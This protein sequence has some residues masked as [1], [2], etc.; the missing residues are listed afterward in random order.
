MYFK[1]L[2][3]NN[4]ASSFCIFV[5]LEIPLAQFFCKSRIRR[6]NTFIKS[7]KL[8]SHIDFLVY[9]AFFIDILCFVSPDILCLKLIYVNILIMIKGA[10]L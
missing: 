7:V 3:P 5:Q 1:N 4:M 10:F 8:F 9:M 2:S 6:Y